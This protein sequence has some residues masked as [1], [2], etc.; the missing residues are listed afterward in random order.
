MKYVKGLRRKFDE[1]KRNQKLEKV[2]GHF[3]SFEWEEGDRF[4]IVLHYTYDTVRWGSLWKGKLVVPKDAEYED[5][6]DSCLNEFWSIYVFRL[7]D[8]WARLYSGTPSDP[9]Y[10]AIYK[11]HKGG[12]EDEETV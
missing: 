7:G 12:G 1:L 3:G 5:F 9:G 11:S 4:D 10:V 6:H 2:K 8:T